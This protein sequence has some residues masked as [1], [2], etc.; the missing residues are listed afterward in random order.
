MQGYS[1]SGRGGTPSPESIAGDP[2]N[3]I[4]SRK[5]PLELETSVA[6]D[7]GANK[8]QRGGS[9]CS[10]S[11]ASSDLRFSTSA[12]PGEILSLFFFENLESDG[13]RLDNLWMIWNL[14]LDFILKGL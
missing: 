3:K 11:V 8:K 1:N 14:T 12:E 5:W 6:R 9:L 7:V 2:R 10:T 4:H 13:D